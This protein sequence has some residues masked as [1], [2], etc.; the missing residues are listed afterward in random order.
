MGTA[1]FSTNALNSVLMTAGLL[2]KTI[3]SGRLKVAKNVTNVDKVVPKDAD[4]W[5]ENNSLG[6]EI[7]WATSKNLAQKWAKII[8]IQSLP[9]SQRYFRERLLY[10]AK[11]QTGS[12]TGVHFFVLYCL[13]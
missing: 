13:L 4:Y 8:H 9:W 12:V 3:I 10:A 7:R 11:C 5:L 6:F 1:R 2:S